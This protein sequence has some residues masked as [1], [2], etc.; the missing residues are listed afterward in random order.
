MG[1]GAVLQPS[2]QVQEV[3]MKSVT[4]LQRIWEGE[5]IHTADPGRKPVAHSDREV[6]VRMR[7]FYER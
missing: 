6:L 7:D 2:G 1:I 4:S 3:Q 5:N